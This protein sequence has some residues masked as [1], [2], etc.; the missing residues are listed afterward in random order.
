MALL[1]LWARGLHKFRP[2]TGGGSE[3]LAGW[4]TGSVDDH[5]DSEEGQLVWNS[6]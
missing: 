2:R 5:G 6:W 3:E 4:R 1:S